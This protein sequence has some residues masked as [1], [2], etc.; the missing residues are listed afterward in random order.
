MTPAGW[1]I[2]LA[3]GA[4]IVIGAAGAIVFSRNSPELKK[5][6]ANLLSH[7]MDLKEKATTFMATAKENMEDIAAEARSEQEK[8]KAGAEAES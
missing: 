4:G 1:K 8:R 5:A 7:G 6:A 2:G 3:L